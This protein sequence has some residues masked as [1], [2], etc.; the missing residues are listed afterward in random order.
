MSQTKQKGSERMKKSTLLNTICM[1]MAAIMITVFMPGCGGGE[2]EQVGQTTNKPIP[3][4]K[5][6]GE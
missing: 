4:K 1:A 3:K 6:K 5:L 2:D